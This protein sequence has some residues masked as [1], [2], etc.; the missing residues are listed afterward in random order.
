VP[1]AQKLQGIVARYEMEAMPYR[2]CI[3]P[4]GTRR[5]ATRHSGASK[6]TQNTN[7]ATRSLV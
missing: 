1:Q 2:V 7:G 5:R 4:P 3:L 6:R